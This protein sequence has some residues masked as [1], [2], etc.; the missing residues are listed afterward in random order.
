MMIPIF[1][2]GQ[3]TISGIVKDGASQEPLIGVYVVVKDT[4]VGVVTDFDGSYKID[5]PKGFN[6]LVFTYV[7]YQPTELI[8]DERSNYNIEMTQGQLLDEVVVI[9]YGTVK[10]EDVTG[11]LQSVSSD[12]FNRGAITGAQ[13]L[14]SGKVPGVSITT[15]GGPGNG[16]KIR[17]RGVSSITASNDPL[18]VI[19]GVPVDNNSISGGRNILNTINPNDIE[20]MT[21]LKDAS[22]AAIYGNRAS[23]GVILITTKKSKV[24]NKLG[25]QYSGNVS[26]GKLKRKIDV[27][28]RD[29]FI[30]ALNYALSDAEKDKAL[31]L[32]G[33][34]DTDWQDEIFQAAIG[35]E[36]NLSFTGAYKFLPYRVSLGYN[37]NNGLLK[38]D[39][40]TRYLGSV[41]LNPKF[42]D[43]RLQ[44]GIYLK[45]MKEVNRFADKG[46]IGNAI[47]FDPTQKI[48]DDSHEY[49]D[50]FAWLNSGIPNTLAPTNP[51][52]LL[53][54]KD[55][56][57]NVN[58]F[59]VNSTI[60]YRFKFLPELRANLNLGYD[61]SIG[62]GT[63]KIPGFIAVS[64]KDESGGGI[65]NEY[66]QIKDNSILEFYL[67]YKKK[68]AS[69]TFD[70]MSGYSWQH[71]K[72]SNYTKESDAAGT[73][74]EITIKDDPYE[75]YLLSLY[76]RFNYSFKDRY[77]LTFTLRRDG[78]SRFSP[79]NRWGLF[80]SAALAI[81]AFENDNKYMNKLKLRLG[82]G[83]IGQENI[84]D[85]YA[86]LANYQ[87]SYENAQ[88]Q[89]GDEFVNTLRP[90]GYDENIKWEENETYNVGIDLSVIDKRMTTT[91]DVYQKNTKDL[92]NYIPVP[93]GT[94]LTNFLTTNVGNMKTQGI[95]FSLNTFDIG[96]KDIKWD[97]SVN[98]AY[99]KSEVTKLLASEDTTYQGV[100]TGG[101][102][103]GV[104]SNIQIYSVGFAPQSFYVYKQKYDEN[105]AILEGEF[106]DLNG[107]GLINSKD[108]YRF[109]KPAPDYTFGFTSSLNYRNF[110]FSFAGRANIGNYVYNNVQTNIGSYESLY[111]STNYLRNVAQS[112]VDL[113]VYKQS[114]L[115]FSDHFIQEASFFKLDHITL[116]YT[117]NDIIG[118]VF[119]VYTTIQNPLVVTKYT[120]LDPEIG[121]GIDNDFYPR[122]RTYLLG[123]SV[124]F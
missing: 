32:I 2:N 41:N 21:I 71:L 103:G 51:V 124:N 65:N 24:G 105:G 102:A 29:E 43:N 96:T 115:T 15:D 20:N 55:D 14:I 101:I 89:F 76:G 106:E 87:A 62:K 56:N 77:L 85:Y 48:K 91:I 67:N 5:V 16:A 7:G 52:A 80:P 120:G 31:P 58:R 44:L 95:E 113:D 109:N 38:T 79:E 57:S 92:L 100:L 18:I 64:Y 111:H 8:L 35:T 123:V 34:A 27:L 84:G 13:E 94:N 69:H 33:E 4:L 19:D 118:K 83:V 93:A 74:S 1:I 17:I 54:Y 9:G 63:V 61:K 60:D 49:G 36:H 88:Y 25:I 107:D 26:Y 23:G 110:N 45:G 28:N 22:S 39:N 98:F 70:I 66:E 108:K 50:Y 75:L 68:I 42:L 82:W 104:G 40:F 119:N 47:N 6:T 11:T 37:N 12:K 117:I 116:S 122:A 97:F 53:H 72:F 112:A 86:Y 99:N 81:K 30:T 10:R 3:K 78:S 59:I 90:N 73:E 121:N 46:A 114:N